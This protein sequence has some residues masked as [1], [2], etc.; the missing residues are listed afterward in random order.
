M[1]ALG[2]KIH[3]Q[4]PYLAERTHDRAEAELFR[5]CLLNQHKLIFGYQIPGTTREQIRGQMVERLHRRERWWLLAHEFLLKEMFRSLHRMFLSLLAVG[6]RGC[7]PGLSLIK[8]MATAYFIRNRQVSSPA[9]L[10]PYDA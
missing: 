3:L 9:G 6:H 10:Q 8:L 4:G 2:A 7:S 5:G 1:I